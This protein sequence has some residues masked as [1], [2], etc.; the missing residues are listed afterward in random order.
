M[1]KKKEGKTK[2]RNEQMGERW[3]QR[4]W[5]LGTVGN[6]RLPAPTRT[7]DDNDNVGVMGIVAFFGRGVPSQNKVK[8]HLFGRGPLSCS[9]I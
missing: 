5:L 1:S 9:L 6:S 2:R 7:S 4:V 8:V 3:W